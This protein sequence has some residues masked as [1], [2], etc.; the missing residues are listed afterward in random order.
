MFVIHVRV[1]GTIQ[2]GEYGATDGTDRVEEAIK[3]LG[4]VTTLGSDALEGKYTEA[5]EVLLQDPGAKVT[6]MVR[7]IV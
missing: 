2:S 1:E 5:Y 7:E 6:V 3:A 4:T